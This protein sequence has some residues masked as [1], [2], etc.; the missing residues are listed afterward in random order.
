VNQQT[1]RENLRAIGNKGD[2]GMTIP[3]DCMFYQTIELPGIGVIPGSWDHREACNVYLGHVDFHGKT[4][5]DVGPANGFFSF[6]MERRGA[7]VVAID[8]GQNSDWDV[9]PH[10]YLDEENSKAN[11]RENVRKVENAFRY[12]HGLLKSK[13]ELVY[14]TVYDVPRLIAPV[15]I[16]L[17]SNVLQHFRDP[18]HAIE[19]VSKVVKETIIITE[20]LWHESPDFIDSSSMRLIP[21][22]ETPECNHSWWQVSPSLIANFLGLLGFPQLKCEIHQQTFNGSATDKNSRK[23]NHFTVTGRRVRNLESGASSS[24]PKLVVAYSN[25]WHAAEGN[26]NHT[27]RWASKT[28]TEIEIRNQTE[29]TIPSKLAFGLASIT[30]DAE[31][32]ILLNDQ[33][34]WHG[35]VYGIRPVFIPSVSL[36]PGI[37]R[38]KFSSATI[39]ISP[40]LKDPRALCYSVYDFCVDIS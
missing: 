10:P 28:E 31:I 18:L 23:L 11:M 25:D 7:K 6:E 5:L 3:D 29:V 27:W 9:V 2:N 37:N 38:L 20:V 12:A 22:A 8:L 26:A 36:T 4:V 32:Q 17:M 40:T 21:R 30:P 14:G 34:M 1:T 39:P 16:A 19:Q 15:D 33:L 24:G 35:N 13:V